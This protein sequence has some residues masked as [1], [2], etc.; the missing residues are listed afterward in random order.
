MTTKQ[1]AGPTYDVEDI[2]PVAAKE[3]LVGNTHNRSLRWRVVDMYAEDMRAGNWQENGESIKIT[4]DGTVVDGQ[5]RLHAIVD[6]GTTQRMLVIRN[7]PMETQTVIDT[8]AKR[9]FADVLKL[10]GEPHYNTVAAVARRVDLWQRGIRTTK[11]NFVASNTQLLATLDA[12]PDIRVS[13]EVGASVRAHVPITAAALGLTHWVFSHL[14]TR[15]AEDLTQLS[16]D[17]KT[18]FDRLADGADLSVN[19]PVYVL[20]RTAIEGSHTK[21]RINE[22]IMTAYVIKAWNAYRAG[23]TISLLRYRPGGANPETFPEPE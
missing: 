17:V 22:S 3:L 12:Y 5:H 21:S 15:D 6:S 4:P 11:G 1:P 2:D 18:F 8:G 14:P 9:T 16:E 13:S 20:R 10:R 23:R 19:H 7:L